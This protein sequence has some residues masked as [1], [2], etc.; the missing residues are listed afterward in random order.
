ML[1]PFVT[2]FLTSANTESKKSVSFKYS[3]IVENSE[4]VCQRKVYNEL[5]WLTKRF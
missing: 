1:Q 4:K 5:I 3:E 2:E